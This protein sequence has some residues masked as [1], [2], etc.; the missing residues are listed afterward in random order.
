MLVEVDSYTIQFNDT[1]Q[2]YTGKK[3]N[4]HDNN[5]YSKY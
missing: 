1:I 4:K 5:K 2:L 3:K